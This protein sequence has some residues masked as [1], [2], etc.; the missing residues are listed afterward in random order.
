LARRNTAANIHPVWLID[1]YVKIRR[2]VW[3]IPPEAPT[4]TDV[5]IIV[6]VEGFVL[7]RYEISIM[8]A[9]FCVIIINRAC[10]SESKA[11]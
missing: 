10:S 11:G 3:F 6:G 2:K 7:I 1:E 4:I 8:D 9:A 5:M